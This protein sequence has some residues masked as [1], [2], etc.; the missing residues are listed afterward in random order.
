M[1]KRSKQLLARFTFT[2]Y[3][4][5]RRHW[6]RFSSKRKRTSS[7]AWNAVIKEDMFSCAECGLVFHARHPRVCYCGA[8]RWLFVLEA[9]APAQL[10]V[11]ERY[12][13]RF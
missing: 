3:L 9:K 7:F 2:S 12:R 1:G 8:V 6:R 10:R 5:W 11:P 4:A 13:P